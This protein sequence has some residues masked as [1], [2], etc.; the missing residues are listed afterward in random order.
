MERANVFDR[1]AARVRH[2]GWK[3]HGFALGMSLAS[4]AMV[5]GQGCAA[6]GG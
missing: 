6:G 4:G 1:L 5:M 3:V 2:L